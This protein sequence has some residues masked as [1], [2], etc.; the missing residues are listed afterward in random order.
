[1]AAGENF[2]DF[3]EAGDKQT[4]ANHPDLVAKEI[5]PYND[6]DFNA[7]LKKLQLYH[8]ELLQKGDRLV[9][10]PIEAGNYQG[11][12]RLEVN[13]LFA[14]TNAYIDL[15]VQI[16]EEYARNKQS[17]Y[18][19]GIKTGKSPSAAEK[20]ANEMTRI[21]SANL[22]IVKLRV[23]QI[24]NEYERYNGIAIYLATRMKEFNTE[25]MMG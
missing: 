3:V 18:E 1:M 9:E 14:W 19:S 21:D 15:Q 2:D 20:H 10:N 11:K 25:R 13:R 12:I 22:A 6:P 17:L 23:D 5:N 7:V 24:K 4:P 16:S 8:A